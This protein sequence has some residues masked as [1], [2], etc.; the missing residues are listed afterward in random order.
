ME[1][2]KKPVGGNLPPTGFLIMDYSV[3]VSGASLVNLHALHA[4]MRFLRP[5]IIR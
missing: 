4:Q 1:A 5:L 2:I 3:S